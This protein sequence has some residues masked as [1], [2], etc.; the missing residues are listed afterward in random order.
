MLGVLVVLQEIIVSILD[1]FDA[2]RHSLLEGLRGL[3]NTHHHSSKK[4]EIKT[5]KSKASTI[6]PSS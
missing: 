2:L 1:V 6:L 5:K 3:K 4:K